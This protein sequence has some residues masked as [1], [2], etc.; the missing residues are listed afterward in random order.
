MTFHNSM[1]MS[2]WI[3]FPILM[4]CFLI[5]TAACQESALN[6]DVIS[7]QSA[8]YEVVF[9]SHGDVQETKDEKQTYMDAFLE[10]KAQYPQQLSNMKLTN[11]QQD[12]IEQHMKLENTT[13]PALLIQRDGETVTKLDGKQTKTKIINQLESILQ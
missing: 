4:S 7:F 2:K 12:L 13:Y 3:C 11:E 10:L 6:I 1:A 9:L 8:D 5:C